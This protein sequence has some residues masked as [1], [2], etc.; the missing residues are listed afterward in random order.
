MQQAF[1]LLTKI[2]NCSHCLLPSHIS[3]ISNIREA[4]VRDRASNLNQLDEQILILTWFSIER[5]NEFR[6]A[7]N[8]RYRTLDV[9][10]CSIHEHHTYLTKRMSRMHHHIQYFQ[11]FQ[12]LNIPTPTDSA[13]PHTTQLSLQCMEVI[14]SVIII[15]SNCSYLQEGLK[16]FNQ[17]SNIK[18]LDSKLTF[19]RHH[20]SL[21]TISFNYKQV[22]MVTITRGQVA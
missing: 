3:S 6:I 13:Q 17:Q 19:P 4:K 9:H 22:K 8:C 14:H 18:P 1:K 21:E 7:K 11:C 20:H 2:C 12:Y 10:H 5:Q 15:A 16:S